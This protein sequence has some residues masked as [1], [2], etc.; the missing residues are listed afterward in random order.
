MTLV[1]FMVCYALSSDKIIH[2]LGY[3]KQVH[4]GKNVTIPPDNR[5]TP[6]LNSTEK[7]EIYFSESV[8]IDEMI[9]GDDTT[10]EVFSISDCN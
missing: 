5:V 7:N 6:L 2:T 4:F 10:F 8:V 3:P 1:N 9:I